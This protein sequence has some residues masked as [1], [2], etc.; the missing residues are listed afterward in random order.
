V[1]RAFATRRSIDRPAE[2]VWRRLTD[3]NRAA[4][5][6]GVDGVRADGPT[7]VGTRLAFRTRG[8]EHTSE[9][10]AVQ[11][12]RSVVLRSIQGGVTADYRYAV[13]PDGTG[14]EV[15]LDADVRTRGLWSLA[16]PMIRAAIR[17]SDTDQLAR[18]EREL[19]SG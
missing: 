18:L 7:A 2:E 4:G 9:I 5:W 11:P 3:W 15:C 8:K 19:T 17:R 14:S 10:T 12:G 1:T 13:E 16:A 6:L